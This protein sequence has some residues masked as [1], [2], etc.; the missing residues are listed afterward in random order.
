MKSMKWIIH[1]IKICKA[2]R[3]NKWKTIRVVRARRVR[4]KK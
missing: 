4:V 3:E 2:K 1:T